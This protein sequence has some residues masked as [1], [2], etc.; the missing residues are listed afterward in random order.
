MQTEKEVKM[1]SLQEKDK[2]N[3][4]LYYNQVYKVHY[5]LNHCLQENYYWQLYLLYLYL[6]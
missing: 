2:S 6:L 5:Y 3:K 4:K 1:L